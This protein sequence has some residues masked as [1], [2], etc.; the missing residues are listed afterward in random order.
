[1]STHAHTGRRGTYAQRETEEMKVTHTEINAFESLHL[2]HSG[3][4][5]NLYY[6]TSPL[7]L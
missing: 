2:M 6:I 5:N 1:M 4:A 7:S 3:N